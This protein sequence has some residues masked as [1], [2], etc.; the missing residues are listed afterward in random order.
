MSTF[1]GQLI[2]FAVIVFVVWRYVVPPVKSLMQKQQDAVRAALAESEEAA[3]KLAD[4]DAMHAK[5]V[6]DA[7]AEAAKVTDEARQDSERIASQLEEQAGVEAERV[8]AQ[9]AQHVQLM[10]QQLIR[11]L[12]LGLGEESVQK[13]D[14]LV[15]SHVSDPEAQSATVDRFLDELEEMAPTSAAIETGAYVRLRAASRA[16][17]VALTHEFDEV[18][19]DL[20]ADGLT[21]LSEELAQVV[22][23]LVN[24][25]TLTRHLT[26]HNDDAEA[27]KSLVDRL[28]TGKLDEKT[29]KLLQTAASQ[30][31]SAEAD[32]IDGIEHLA[33]LALLKRAELEDQVD[34]VEEQLFRFGRILDGQPRLT[35]LLSDYTTPLEGRT[36]LLDKVID[37]S[38]IDG[39]AAALLSQTIG[40]LR[41]ERADEAVIDLAELAVARRGELVAHVTAAAD[42]SDEQRNRLVE[43]L[44]RIYGH[45]V[46]IQLNVDPEVLGGLSITVGDEVIDGSIATRLAAAQTQLPD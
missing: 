22:T 12:R 24:E 33:R 11:Q 43:L 5:A 45:P 44:S 32:L 40:H 25:P 8:K 7:E 39:I 36:A 9:G 27:K 16:A 31:W 4:A 30:R 29:V 13:A 20:D 42:L 15:R 34:D 35:A 28:F 1:I 37:G 46:S 19:S 21:K 18:A 41:G 26:E 17:R 23:L 14:E 38:G 2:G 10:R 6:K 3:R